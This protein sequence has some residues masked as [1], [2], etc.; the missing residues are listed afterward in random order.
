VEAV[1]KEAEED[2]LALQD[3]RLELH[4][5]LE[6]SGLQIRAGGEDVRGL[7]LVAEQAIEVFEDFGD[8][9]G[10][11]NAWDYVA[12]TEAAPCRWS[13]VE[14]ALWR[15]LE[16]AER[17]QAEELRGRSL[18]G[19][20]LALYMGPTPAPEATRRIT[21]ISQGLGD[22]P[23]YARAAVD[24][25]L[26]CLK[27]L[28]GDVDGARALLVVATDILQELGLSWWLASIRGQ[29]A[30]AV[31]MLAGSPAAAEAEFRSS[32]EDLKKMGDIGG[33]ATVAARLAEALYVQRLYEE[34]E[35]LTHECE[36][37]SACTDLA[38]QV[39]WRGTRAKVLARRG[40]FDEAEGLALDAVARAAK[41][42][43]LNMH[44]DVLMGLA[45]I[46]GLMN[47]HAEAA[48]A[49]G[50]ALD[51]YKTKG[52]IVSAHQASHQLHA[53]ATS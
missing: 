32:Y 15:S 10:L 25:Y 23:S 45:E 47:R 18:N 7:R 39:W 27:A 48:A 17:A 51:L 38:S 50:R 2:A 29:A 35:H 13:A 6:R 53:L 40:L 33:L 49:A 5:R 22:A 31:E 1:L 11:A 20:V 19:I 30:G 42:D 44:G 16:H 14:R 4:A 52:N 28:R 8:E 43:D 26:A 46:L 3:R 9:R 37:I 12:V 24:S 34:A 41:S 36:T 21:E